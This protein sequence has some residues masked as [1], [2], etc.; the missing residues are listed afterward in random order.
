MTASQPAGIRHTYT[1]PCGASV[2]FLPSPPAG[3]R[4]RT[5]AWCRPPMERGAAESRPSW[6]VPS[7]G[8]G[9]SDIIKRW[10]WWVRCPTRPTG[11]SGRPDHEPRAAGRDDDGNAAPPATAASAIPPH[12]HL[13]P[14]G[15]Q[16]ESTAAIRTPGTRQADRYGDGIGGA[17]VDDTMSE[18][19]PPQRTSSSGCEPASVRPH[20]TAR[21]AQGAAAS[22]PCPARRA[23]RR[24]GRGPCSR[25]REGVG[26]ELPHRHRVHAPR[27]R[28]H[29]SPISTAG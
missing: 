19:Q 28:R 1:E 9:R 12:H 13:P 23:R 17:S 26:R 18:Q 16:R 29:A 21:V 5:F 2:R 24:A 4:R 27:G 22:H 11:W 8:Q 15:D 20:A 14:R 3:S 25:P 10:S 6:P 7:W